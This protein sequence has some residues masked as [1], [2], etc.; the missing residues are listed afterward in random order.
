MTRLILLCS[1]A[2]CLSMP[3]LADEQSP[4]LK[5]GEL[6]VD[7][8]TKLRERTSEGKGFRKTK[9]LPF[10]EVTRW[11][12]GDGFL[13]IETSMGAGIVLD[14]T[15]VVSNE[16]EQEKKTLKVKDVDLTKGEMTVML[17]GWPAETPRL[18]P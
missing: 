17:P 6:I 5:R 10:T 13:E 1:V 3:A 18:G 15:Y 14:I 11:G 12:L 7:H 8:L 16:K 9:T 4:V 2:L